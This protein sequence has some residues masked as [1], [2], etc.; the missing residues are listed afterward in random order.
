[1]GAI[2][3]HSRISSFENCPK[4]FEFRYVQ[5]I[6][7]ETES[8]EAFVG[9]RVHEVFERL[10]Q[11]AGRGQLPGVEKVVDRYHKLWEEAY[12]AERVRI[13]REGA[14]LGFYRALGERCVRGYYLRHY[15]F[16]DGETLGLEKRVVFPL[17]DAGD[18]R[19]QGIIDRIVRAR[20]GAIEVHDYKTGA[21]VPP[22]RALDEDRQLALYQ[23]GLAREY[24]EDRPFRLVWH[25]V[26]KDVTRVSTR[27]PEA[28]EAL[29]QTTIARIDEIRSASSYPPRKSALCSW[30]EYRAICPA[31]AAERPAAGAAVA[32][33]PAT[34]ETAPGAD[35]T[36]SSSAA[37]AAAATATATATE[38]TGAPALA[39][40]VSATPQA[41]RPGPADGEQLRLL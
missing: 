28:L 10:Y 13:V 14:T 21:R 41:E 16:D 20:D 2:F 34:D 3:S 31:F 6:E 9:K 33:P 36:T 37:A 22:Q 39:E 26:A 24:G 11:F 35:A 38:I 29:R 12:D 30:C 4:Q 18:Y 5:K 23:L 27:T 7:S 40:P 32:L 15:P 17:D 1:M 25:F 8:I 19:M